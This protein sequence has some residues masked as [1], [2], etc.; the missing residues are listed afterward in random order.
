MGALSHSVQLR[1]L[2]ILLLASKGS[3][4]AAAVGS[5]FSWQ[6]FPRRAKSL[7]QECPRFSSHR[8][9]VVPISA[10]VTAMNFDWLLL[11]RASVIG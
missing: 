8:R 5:L 1:L 11:R 9:R 3:V 4:G 7:S 10:A 6:C 2:G